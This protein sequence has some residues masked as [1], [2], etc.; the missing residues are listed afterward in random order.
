M[1]GTQPAGPL[2]RLT[3]EKGGISMEQSARCPWARTDHEITYHDTEWCR[4]CHDDRA[5]F[6]L[7][8]L[9]GF[10]AGLSW[11]LILER[12]QALREAFAGFDP[13]LLARWGDKDIQAALAAPGIIRNRAKARCA[14]SNAKA[15]LKVQAEWGSFDA[16]LWHW[17]EGRPIVNS[18]T[19]LDQVPA[20]TE[21]S[22]TVS[23]DLRRRGFKFVGPVIVYS[24]LQAAG[25]I[26]DHLVSCPWHKLC[27]EGAP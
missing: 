24:Y 5:L 15:F 9:E 6:E 23:A 21:L 1:I 12:R 13:A 17:V 16:Y 3:D 11:G 26:N 4:P 19:S 7:L 10:Q 18:W 8:E 14:V 27:G 25:L 20:E 22:R 2:R